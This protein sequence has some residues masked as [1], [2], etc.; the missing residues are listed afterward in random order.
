MKSKHPLSTLV[1]AGIAILS[2][3]GGYGIQGWPVLPVMLGLAA[4]WLLARKKAGAWLPS[5]LLVIYLGLAVYGLQAGYSPLM[6][7]LGATAALAWWDLVLLPS[8]KAA[9]LPP[10]F[11]NQHLRSLALAAGLGLLLAIAGLQIH[12]ELPFG[13]ILLLA[14][15][16]FAALE[17]VVNYFRKKA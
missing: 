6:M 15:L 9:P 5:C 13:V 10:D 12:L 1:C 2:L 8:N 14:V 3:T 17:R 4:V 7:I 11:V 16:I